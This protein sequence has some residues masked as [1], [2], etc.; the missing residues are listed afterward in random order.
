MSTP[1]ILK[2]ISNEFSRVFRHILPG[3]IVLGSMFYSH[4]SWF[5]SLDINKWTNIIILLVVALII[6][7]I[8]YVIHRYTIHNLLDWIMYCVLNRKLTGYI[9]WLSS[10]IIKS[11]SL[12]DDKKELQKH[13]HFRSA[14]VIFVFI[15]AEALIIFGKWYEPNS[16]F[17]NN[18]KKIFII[19]CVLLIAAIIQFIISY[20]LDIAAVTKF[21]KD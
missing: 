10:H 20:F 12:P 3:F 14:Q 11:F 13:I 6:G 21:T 2:S 1:D 4:P 19:G 7:N 17:Q 8:W 18:N 15:T 16:P 9:K 5:V